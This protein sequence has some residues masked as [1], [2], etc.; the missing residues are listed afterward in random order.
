MESPWKRGEQSSMCRT[1]RPHAAMPSAEGRGS[2]QGGSSFK[3]LSRRGE[4]WACPGSRRR[5]PCLCRRR[6]RHRPPEQR[7]AAGAPLLEPGDRSRGPARS[8][9]LGAPGPCRQR[10]PQLCQHRAGGGGSGQ[11]HPL[12]P[13]PAQRC[14]SSG[15][16]ET[17][18]Q[19]LMVCAGRPRA[20]L[21][22]ALPCAGRRCTVSHEKGSDGG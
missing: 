2:R 18:A 7:E 21:P 8:T 1:R 22:R 20:A 19:K 14:C 11:P 12:V 15:F 5:H 10:V 3:C 16:A 6:C 13:A 17:P 4:E 9:A